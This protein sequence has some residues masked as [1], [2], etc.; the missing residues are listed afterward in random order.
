[1]A[2]KHAMPSTSSVVMSCL[3]VLPPFQRNGYGRFLVDLSKT[4]HTV[5]VV[6]HRLSG[7]VCT[8]TKLFSDL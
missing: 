5:Y 1:M 2:S 3:F 6:I 8:A 4:V 7:A